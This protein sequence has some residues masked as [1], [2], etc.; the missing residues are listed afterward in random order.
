[1][2]EHSLCARVEE[3]AMFKKSEPLTLPPNRFLDWFWSKKADYERLH[4]E[5]ESF[6]IELA[7]LEAQSTGSDQFWAEAAHN[8]LDQVAHYLKARRNVEGGWICLHAA[9]RHAIHLLDRVDLPLQA[10]MLRAESGKFS[11]WRATEMKNLL[12]VKDEQLTCSHIMNAMALR[13]EYFSNQYHKMWLVGNQLAVLLISCG[14]GLLLLVP[15]VI[16]FSL[17]PEGTL[18]T[19][20]EA[21][22]TSWGYQMVTAVLFFGLLGAAF[23]AALSLINATGETRIPERVANGFVTSARALFGAGVGLAGY[24][25]YQTKILELHIDADSGVGGA[26]AVA[27]LFGFAGE[28][29][30]GGVLGSLGASKS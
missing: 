23:G 27:F 22:I 4:L 30:I 14:L 5:Y 7:L 11:S 8:Q 18:N 3:S 17:H 21:T 20:P 9:R 6:R 16:F 25:F 29:L 28:R 19:H 24:A 26:L 10:S 15:L 12:S 2:K 1:M 13:D